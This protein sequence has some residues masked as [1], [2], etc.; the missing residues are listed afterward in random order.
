MKWTHMLESAYPDTGVSPSG[1]KASVF[2]TDIR[3]FESSYP[4]QFGEMF[5]LNSPIFYF[6]FSRYFSH[7]LYR[8]RLAPIILFSIISLLYLYIIIMNKRNLK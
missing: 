6:Q 1:T 4:N 8:G 7:L 5:S 3:W 2:D